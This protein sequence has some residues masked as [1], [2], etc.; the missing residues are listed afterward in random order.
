VTGK[1]NL[2]GFDSFGGFSFTGL[3]EGPGFARITFVFFAGGVI[4]VISSGWKNNRSYL[5]EMI[6]YS[7]SGR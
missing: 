3:G 2:Y 4:C 7:V 1:A 6:L 5:S